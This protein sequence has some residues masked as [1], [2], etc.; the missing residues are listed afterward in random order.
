MASL[1]IYLV[2]GF[3]SFTYVEGRQS[4][5]ECEGVYASDTSIAKWFLNKL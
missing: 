2:A 4:F 1:L 5:R 3:T